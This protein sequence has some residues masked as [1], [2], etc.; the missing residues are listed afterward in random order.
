MAINPV[1]SS[2][3]YGDAD[4]YFLNGFPY[5]DDLL[6][7]LALTGTGEVILNR[8]LREH[9]LTTKNVYRGSLIREKLSYSGNNPKKLRVALQ[10]VDVPAY[11]SLLLDE[12]LDIKPNVIVPL[13]D[14]ALSAVFPYISTIKKPKGRK[15]WIDCYR[16]SI[17]KLRDDW[18]AKI[19]HHI[20]VIPTISP[21]MLYANPAAKAYI[22][23]D[24]SKIVANAH[25]QDAIKEYGIRWVAKDAK[26][27]E[28]YF[29]RAF[30]KQP[31]VMTFDIETY[32]GLL[33]CISFCFDGF[34]AV[35]VP[36]NQQTAYDKYEVAMIW[37]LVSKALAHPIGKVN[38]N[39]KYDLTILER[40]GFVVS[41]IIG[42]TMLKGHLLY[43][44]LPKGLDF[45]T[46]IYTPLPYY[47]DEGKEY[48][49]KLHSRDRLY[50]YN[51]Q[52][53]IAA[54]IVDSEQDK[55]LEEHP[56]LAKLYKE[57]IVPLIVIYKNID[58][59]GILVDQEFKT[60]LNFKYAGL[61]ESNRAM[62][63][64]LINND[65]FNPGSWQQVGKLIYEDLKFPKRTKTDE[66]GKVSYKTDKDTL[67][68]LSI[69]HAD[70]NRLGK[71]G[72]A[73]LNRLVVCRKIL[74]VIEYI[75][76]NL[77][78][79]GTFRGTSNLAGTE[80]GRSSFSKSLDETYS[81][82]KT[83][84]VK[85]GRSLQTISKHGFTL[86]EEVFNDWTDK[87]IANDM[88]S[89]FVPRRD[90]VFV[91]GDGSQAEARVVA[92][93][94]EDWELLASFDK[95]PKVHA[96]TAALIFGVD[97]GIITK[98]FPSIPNLGIPYYDMGKRI[99]H[100]GNYNMG[101]HR[102]A[103]MTHLSVY[104]CQKLLDRFHNAEP[105]L[106]GVFHQQIYEY[107]KKH[108]SLVTPFGRRRDF[109]SELADSVYKE[110]LAYIPQS[111]ISDLTKFTLRRIIAD[112]GW[113][114]RFLT[115]QHDGILAEIHKSKVMEYAQA[116][117]RNYERTLDFRLCS[118]FR[119]FVLTVPCELSMSDE[120]WMNLK[121]F[122][123]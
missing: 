21:Q 38:Q 1:V 34:E 33:T 64:Q 37:R 84:L 90:H 92:V 72:A 94:A 113:E 71:T 101:A 110:A 76:T 14:I 104:E 86:D 29:Q 106:R 99:R 66:Y 98:D 67:D 24:F 102:L 56:Q 45:Y 108:R 82:N 61:Y 40:H 85:L 5:K 96:K 15:Y 116:F 42:D 2:H 58:E 31:K 3:G 109:F 7:G 79:D 22:A 30:A 103:Q 50:L 46:S 100:A 13:D 52:D 19:Q 63:S 62:L 23:L 73:I 59:R 88:R 93:L 114:P 80:T 41:N 47:K 77:H 55:D 95:K 43:P 51:A 32:G 119:D 16:G 18:Q 60:K 118:L 105:Q 44:E 121:E 17:L 97:V 11:Q 53:S 57:E 122:Y 10:E 20:R 70:Q 8:F 78:P 91:E 27:L 39:I 89:M 123:V 115:E 75:N 107:L 117:K 65:K 28:T 12:I 120:N 54:H 25:K 111:T 9:K 87:V 68:D 6:A 81:W 74:K 26:T 48:D 35:S 83:K 69:H 4:I 49:P 36:M 112:L